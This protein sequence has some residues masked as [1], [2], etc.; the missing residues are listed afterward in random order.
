LHSEW[1]K[2]RHGSPP[3]RGAAGNGP[4]RDDVRPMGGSFVV[5]RTDPFS[6]VFMVRGVSGRDRKHP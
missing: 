2:S 5:K 3:G 6:A 1:D 4:K